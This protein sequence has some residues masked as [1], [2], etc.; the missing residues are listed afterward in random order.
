M[1]VIFTI[2]K[3]NKKIDNQMSDRRRASVA[4]LL[5]LTAGELESHAPFNTTMNHN[6][7]KRKRG[8]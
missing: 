1:R 6:L 4:P 8:I 3:K 7:I 2:F 5:D